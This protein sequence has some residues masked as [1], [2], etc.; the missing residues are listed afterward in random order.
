[1]NENN[2]ALEICDDC[3]KPKKKSTGSLTQWV[4]GEGY[5]DCGRKELQIDEGV[6]SLPDFC[7]TCGKRKTAGR[8]GSLTQWIFRQDVCRCEVPVDMPRP[9]FRGG[10]SESWNLDVEPEPEDSLPDLTD[11]EF[12]LERFKP[13]RRLGRGAMGAVFECYDRQLRRNVAVKVLHV[14]TPEEKVQFQLEARAS[15]LLKHPNIVQVLDFGVTAGDRPY[16]VMSL[17][18][19][20]TLSRLLE[21]RG[22]LG[23]DESLL[24]TKQLADA[25]SCAHAAG[26]YH[27]DVKP[28]NIVV[29]LDRNGYPEDVTVID[30]GVA[31]FR[32]P[33]EQDSDNPTLAG[34][35]L[36]MSP[37]QAAGL[38]YDARSEAYSVG[39][40]LFEMLTGRP[41]F[42]GDS[43][44]Q[45]LNQHAGVEPPAVSSLTDSVKPGSALENVISVC[46]AKNRD[47]RFQTMSDLKKAI[48]AV[49]IDIA[50]SVAAGLERAR[51]EQ[52]RELALAQ[53]QAERQSR[54]RI[55]KI[56]AF[57]FIPLALSA[58]VAAVL[59]SNQASQPTVLI[60]P[61]AKYKDP[62]FKVAETGTEASDTL[63]SM[64]EVAER[65]LDKRSSPEPDQYLLGSNGVTLIG[66]YASDD[67]IAKTEI[68]PNYLNHAFIKYGSVSDRG[69]EIIAKK[70]RI[71]SIEMW[72]LNNVT[73]AGVALIARDAR[74]LILN[75]MKITPRF[76]NYMR[77]HKAIASLDIRQTN[78]SGADF[79]LLKDCPLLTDLTLRYCRLTD[80]EMPSILTIKRLKKLDVTGGDIDDKSLE[81]FASLPDLRVIF[82]AACRRVSPAGLA[83]FKQLKPGC[84]VDDS[85]PYTCSM[86]VDSYFN[87]SDFKKAVE[88]GTDTIDAS[89]SRITDQAVNSLIGKKIAT[90]V[91]F[92]T[93]LTDKAFPTIAKVKTLRQLDMSSM[94]RVTDEGL[95]FV[96]AMK[97][98]DLLSIH[99]NKNLSDAAIAE[100]CKQLPLL[101]ELGASKTRIGKATFNVLAK[102]TVFNRLNIHDDNIHDDDMVIIAKIPMQTLI[103]HA[104][105][106]VTARG[107]LELA[108]C[109]TLKELQVGPNASP[110]VVKTLKEHLKNCSIVTVPK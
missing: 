92:N 57:C 41:P 21:E 36:Y 32:R 88:C 7:F 78:L 35:P 98:L 38:D 39:C 89:N 63:G 15:A 10:P 82:I 99:E 29:D 33:E 81:S 103:M 71:E 34:T 69:L 110:A 65:Q 75:Q 26:I 30:F 46:L 107:F 44:M 27:R 13:I 91:I 4:F 106:D 102:K 73:D 96:G 66:K 51:T 50:E 2:P 59:I 11:K 22:S 52:S 54:N 37:D 14:L 84:V 16:M 3:F 68:P 18:K 20:R 62:V 42:Q 47:E 58:G 45:L 90:L 1:M 85:V 72:A 55:L 80:R 9:Q 77:D 56:A 60:K 105:P 97:K 79:S 104:N 61:L 76:F 19:G 23:P 95:Y 109:S 87:D 101:Q 94:P 5:C 70:N 100:V 24:V 8:A 93:N 25:L 53:A 108:K 17:V 74:G 64:L 48:E 12:P 40:V 43:V 86:N 83:R 67:F 31:R 6:S 49:E 28:A